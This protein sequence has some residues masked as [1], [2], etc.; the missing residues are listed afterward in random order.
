MNERTGA[1]CSYRTSDIDSDGTIVA[2][3][4]TLKTI[5]PLTNNDFVGS[6]CVYASVCVHA[7]MYAC[8]ALSCALVRNVCKKV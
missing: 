1:V 5:F 4:H 6:S 8:Y 7:C 3:T 2:K